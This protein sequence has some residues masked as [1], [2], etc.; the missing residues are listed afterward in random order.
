MILDKA[1]ITNFLFWEKTEQKRDQQDKNKN[2]QQANAK[3]RKKS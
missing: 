3:M 1:H 2:D